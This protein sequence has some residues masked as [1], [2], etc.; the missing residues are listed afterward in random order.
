MAITQTGEQTAI[1]CLQNNEWKLDQA[2][3][4]YFQQP[5]AYYRDLDHKKIEQLFRRYEETTDPTKM[6]ACTQTLSIGAT[7][8]YQVAV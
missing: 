1:F 5:Q 7:H 8:A 6:W 4:N 2:S 3:D